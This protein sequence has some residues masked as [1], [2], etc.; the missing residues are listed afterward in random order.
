MKVDVLLVI[1]L[2]PPNRTKGDFIKMSFPEPKGQY[3]SKQ[4]GIESEIKE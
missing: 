1:K 3:I 2:F 4:G